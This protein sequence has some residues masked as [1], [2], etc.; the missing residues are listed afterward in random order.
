MLSYQCS[1][2][3]LEKQQRTPLQSCIQRKL[4][5]PTDGNA[6]A[7]VPASVEGVVGQLFPAMTLNEPQELPDVVSEAWEHVIHGQGHK[8]VF[9]ESKA[10]KI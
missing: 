6:L 5:K 1:L 10:V 4:V 2:D 8:A 7:D 9:G 3:Q